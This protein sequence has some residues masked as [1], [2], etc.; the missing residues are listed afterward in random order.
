MK[1][2][3]LTVVAVGLA[4]VLATE[5]QASPFAWFRRGRPVMVRQAPVA[6]VRTE[7]G[8]RTFSY[9]PGTPVIVRA[10]AVRH[11]Q[12]AYTNATNKTLGKYEPPC[13]RRH[14]G[15]RTAGKPVVSRPLVHFRPSGS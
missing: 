12:P 13:R 15:A 8:Y 14:L 5:A 3:I 2:L 4:T 10:P 7:A 9:E 6:T 1:K 11:N